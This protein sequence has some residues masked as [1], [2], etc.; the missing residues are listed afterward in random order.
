[1]VSRY[2][3]FW[4]LCALFGGSVAFAQS[5]SQCPEDTVQE[6]GRVDIND[7][8]YVLGNF[9]AVGSQYKKN[10]SADIDG[11]GSI[12]GADITRVL[13]KINQP[14][15]RCPNDFS[16][17]GVV[18]AADLT[19]L[20]ANPGL[21][22][23]KMVSLLLDWG[24]SCPS[25]SLKSAPTRKKFNTIGRTTMSTSVKRMNSAQRKTARGAAKRAAAYLT[26]LGRL[27]GN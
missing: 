20:L 3:C 27:P 18:D 7:L 16:N 23:T 11:D 26:S 10:A 8:I 15:N 22:S 6:F 1:M 9:G 13:S 2:V 21:D 17:D 24:M 4:G 12:D 25:S 5:E 14:C 19:F